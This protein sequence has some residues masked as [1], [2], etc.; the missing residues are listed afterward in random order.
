M[1]FYRVYLQFEGENYSDA[2]LWEN[3]GYIASKCKYGGGFNVLCNIN[4]KRL[5]G[6]KAIADDG[7]I[8]IYNERELRALTREFYKKQ[9]E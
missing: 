5:I 3:L 2:G 1:N 8:T 7:S 6:L 9:R 4:K